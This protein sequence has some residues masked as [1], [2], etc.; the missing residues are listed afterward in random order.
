MG[1]CQTELPE[2]LKA[3]ES[4]SKSSSP[5]LVFPL[6]SVCPSSIWPVVPTM[7]IL[8]EIDAAVSVRCVQSNAILMGMN[9]VDRKAGVGERPGS[10][11]SL[12]AHLLSP[13]G[14]L[15]AKTN[16]ITKAPEQTPTLQARPGHLNVP[17]HR[18]A[19]YLLKVPWL[20]APG[21]YM[22]LLKSQQA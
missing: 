12:S 6:R 11:L 18:C 9:N 4:Q 5:T 22:W 10:E 8:P 15:Q 13:V 19:L 16:E 1:Q 21:L 7:E 14:E 2:M 20:E 3:R 17:M